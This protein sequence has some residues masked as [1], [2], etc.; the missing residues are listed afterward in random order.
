MVM[1]REE[2][3]DDLKF[4]LELASDLSNDLRSFR[5]TLANMLD[6]NEHKYLFAGLDYLIDDSKNV[7]GTI[8]ITR[9]RMNEDDEE[10]TNQVP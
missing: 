5:Q 7:W 1:T 6:E 8:A 4:A 9:F 10:S 3:K 2:I